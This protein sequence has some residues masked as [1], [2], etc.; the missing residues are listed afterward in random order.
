MK[1]SEMLVQASF[2][3]ARWTCTPLTYPI[4]INKK[5]AT[6][7]CNSVLCHWSEG[8]RMKYSRTILT[9]TPMY[10]SED[11]EKEA[12]LGRTLTVRCDMLHSRVFSV[13]GIFVPGDSKF[14]SFTWLTVFSYLLWWKSIIVSAHVKKNFF[15]C[16]VLVHA[17]MDVAEQCI[18][19][20]YSP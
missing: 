7:T 5:C 4:L 19:T 11:S 12:T 15:Y 2:Y 13:F 20:Y 8:L 9:W 1:T 18:S 10:G 14:S 3:K 16:A 17:F 6:F